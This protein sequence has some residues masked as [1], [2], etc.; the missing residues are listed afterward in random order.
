MLY[1]EVID[2]S[3]NIILLDTCSFICQVTSTRRQRIKLF[4]F[5]SS[6]HLYQSWA[7]AHIV[8]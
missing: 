7:F 5:E 3:V 4:I 2:I 1:S 8:R 6:W